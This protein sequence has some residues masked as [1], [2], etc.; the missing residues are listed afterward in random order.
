MNWGHKIMVV[1]LIFVAGILFLVY[2]TS[3]EKV[4]LVTKDYYAEEIQYQKKIDQTERSNALSVPITFEIVNGELTIHFPSEFK[5]KKITGDIL[6]YCPSD[7]GKDIK[8]SFSMNGSVYTMKLPAA[9]K[10]LHVLKLN[11][12]I[13]GVS[14]YFEK[15]LSL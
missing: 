3:Q 7:E 1:Y 13:D 6:L 15:K 10:G 5:E 11:W 2:K 12:T 8:Q 9:N 14:Y 4:D